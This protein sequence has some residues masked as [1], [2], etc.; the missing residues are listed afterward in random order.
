MLYDPRKHNISRIE[1]DAGVKFEHVSAP[2]A[3]DI[4]TSVAHEISAAILAVSDSVIPAFQSAADKLIK[5]SGL[6][7]VD[8]LSKA[9]A[10]AS[11][12]TEIKSRSLLNSMENYVTVQ[13]EA[14]KP[15]YSPS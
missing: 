6:S 1:R 3:T 10:K 13:L 14:G 12:Y 8:L 11:G 15:I 9:L 2:Q 5:T 4:A 7:P